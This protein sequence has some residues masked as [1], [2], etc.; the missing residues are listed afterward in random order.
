MRRVT[1]SEA[2]RKRIAEML[3]KAEGLDRSELVRQAARLVIE[4]ALEAEVSEALG[5][6]YY[7]RGGDELQGQR[8]GYRCGKLEGA[9]GLIEY[10]IPQVR[11][12]PGWQSEVRVALCGKTEELERLA[13]EMYARGLSMR[14]IEAAFTDASGRCVLSRSAAS[15]VAE[16][17]WVDYQAFATRSLAEIPMVYLYV[18]GVAERLHLGQPREA[19]LAAWGIAEDGAKH[20]LGLLPGTKE[21]TASAREFLRDLKA[22]GLPDPV[23]IITDGAPGLIRAVEE[24]FPKSLRQ[25]CLAHK[26]RNLQSKVPEERWREVIPAARAI[27]QAPSP[28]LARIAREEFVKSWSKELPSAVV[29]F[30]D[31]FEA[32]IAHLRLPIAHRRVTRTTNLLERL[33]LEERR[34][35]KT[36]PHAFGE[37]AVLKLMFAAILRASQSWLGIGMN[38]FERRQLQTLR[39]ELEQQFH[40]R[41]TVSLKP[42][43]HSEIYSNRRT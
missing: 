19:I 12:L 40:E 33:F 3:R 32:C 39:E 4:E 30:E 36:I 25:R 34:R 43:S 22:R 10:A 9:E 5:R 16:Q 38:D 1:A 23:A 29:C 42:A 21:D 11:G 35:T 37:R 18:D 24:V 13:I 17:L 26:L 20:L 7:D 14:D 6:G 2:T 31:D 27:Y 15:R 28:A 8:N 41:H